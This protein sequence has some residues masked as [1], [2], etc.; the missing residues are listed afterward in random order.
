MFGRGKTQPSENHKF[1]MMKG[2][3][4]GNLRPPPKS[5]RKK[6]RGKK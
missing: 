3:E 5:P 2:R 4:K 6:M 1:V